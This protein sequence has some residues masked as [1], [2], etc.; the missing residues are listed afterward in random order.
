MFRR[1]LPY[2]LLLLLGVFLSCGESSNLLSSKTDPCS[3]ITGAEAERAL[4][5]PVQEAARS[6]STTC[7]FKARRNTSNAVTIQVDETPGKDRRSWFNKERLRRDSYLLP[8]LADGAVRIDSPPSLSRV[9]FIHQDALVTV[10]VASTKQKD[11]PKAVTLL[12]QNAA[13]R[14]GA[15]TLA[16]AGSNTAPLAL[17]S[18][19]SLD[20]ST[21]TTAP[22]RTAPVTM[23]QTL[24]ASSGTTTGPTK[25]GPIDPANLAGTWHAHPIQGRMKRDMLLVIQPNREWLLSS[26]IQFD[27]I[28]DAEAGHW[29]FERANTSKGL[30]WKGTYQGSM[31]NSF[32]STGSIR[33]TWARLQGDQGPAHIPTELWRLR[34]EATGIPSFQLKTVDPELVGQWEGAGTYPGGSASFVWSIKPSTGA[35]LLIVNQTRGTV[36]TNGGIPQ[37]QPVY[38]R[39]RSLSIVAFQEGGFTTSDGKASIRWTRLTPE[40]TEDPRL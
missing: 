34:R 8:G 4:G 35:D 32:S 18:K 29:A 21:L 37:L 1:R 6:D 31:A 33:A 16:A 12:G 14:Y 3:L 30:A 22:T 13:V 23:T 10:M 36:E 19:S 27:G 40:S 2:S 17:S 24:P 28:L 11:L 20:R 25:L 7:V 15:P 26:M 38:K 5:E 39:H 9:T